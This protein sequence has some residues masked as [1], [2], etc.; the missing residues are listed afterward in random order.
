MF[1]A[2]MALHLLQLAANIQLMQGR[3]I[4][5]AESLY[6]PLT[7]SAV[8]FVSQSHNELSLKLISGTTSLLSLFFSSLFPTFLYSFSWEHFIHKSHSKNF[9]LRCPFYKTDLH[10]CCCYYYKWSNVLI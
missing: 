2:L 3:R 1:P 6:L 8:K 5:K 10:Y 7:N 9:L 4:Q